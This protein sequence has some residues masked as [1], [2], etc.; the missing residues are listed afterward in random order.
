MGSDTGKID[1]N[2]GTNAQPVKIPASQTD[3]ITK[4]TD[5][6]E[7]RIELVR[8]NLMQKFSMIENLFT[9]LFCANHFDFN[10]A[11]KHQITVF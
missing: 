11:I 1:R 7:M 8:L 6:I 2:Y 10:R 5:K 4:A 3:F 9:A